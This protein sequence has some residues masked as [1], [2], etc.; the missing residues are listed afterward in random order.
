MSARNFSILLGAVLLLIGLWGMATGGHDHELIVFGVNAN[1]NWVH[2]LS[3]AVGLVAGFMGFGRTFLIAFGA[4]YGLVTI[5]GF[6]NVEPVT[7]GLNLNMADNFLHLGISAA[8]LLV[9]LRRE[10]GVAARHA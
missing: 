1:H 7:S 6:A 3:G 10:G 4:V 9:G 2:L 8:S 5:L